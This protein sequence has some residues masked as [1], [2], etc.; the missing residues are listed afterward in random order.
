MRNK[1]KIKGISL[2]PRQ[3]EITKQIISSKAKYITLNASRQFSKSTILENVLMYYSLNEYNRKILYITPTYALSR[4]VMEK[5]NNNLVQSGVISSYNKSD[6]YIKF[7]NGSE[8]HFRS[9]TNEDTIRG[10][11]VHYL[12]LDEAA[13]MSD[14]VWNVARPTM[15]VLGIKCIMASTPRGKRG[16]FFQ[17]CQLGQT[18]DINYLYLFGHYRD[19]PFYRIDEVEQAKLVMPENIYLQEYEAQ[20]LEDGG[21]VFRNISNCQTIHSFKH[22]M[23][24]GPYAIGIDLGRQNDYTVV[25]VLNKYNEVVDILRTNKQDWTVII[26]DINNVLKKYP[27]ANIFCE[28]NGIGDVVFDLLRKSNSSIRSFTTTN[29]S[30]NE[31]IEELIYAFQNGSI[32]IPTQQLFQ[33]LHQE[34]QTFSFKYSQQTRRI[35]YGASQLFNDDCVMSLAIA[36]KAK[37][38]RSMGYSKI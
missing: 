7:I 30:K 2:F 29:E 19:N 36:L 21:S 38:K 8:I 6:N 11:S 18:D 13:F 14:D 9:A 4:I 1:I 25:T 10:L 12:I 5:L 27:G 16:F 35:Q 17:H 3:E 31:I 32:S 34:L 23:N 33:A 20:F 15:A 37:Q 24:E 28:T 26:G 22:N